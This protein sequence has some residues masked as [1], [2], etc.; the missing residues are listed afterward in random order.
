MNA[1]KMIII[2][3]S[4]ISAIVFFIG[5]LGYSAIVLYAWCLKRDHHA[6]REIEMTRNTEEYFSED[7]ETDAES[8][9]TDLGSSEDW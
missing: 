4:V 1:V 3:A 6:S 7:S 5:L 9:G 8:S 2:G